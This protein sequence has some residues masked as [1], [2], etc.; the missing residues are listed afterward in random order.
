VILIGIIGNYVWAGIKIFKFNSWWLDPTE[1][2]QFH[3]SL[4]LDPNIINLNPN[5]KNMKEEDHMNI[6]FL[7]LNFIPLDK[8]RPVVPIV[9]L[10]NFVDKIKFILSITV[11][12]FLQNIPYITY[13][14]CTVL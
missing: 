8:K 10:L 12:V 1:N 2:N 14:I 6:Y 4:S 13:T 9:S 11:I 7:N 5:D 3:K